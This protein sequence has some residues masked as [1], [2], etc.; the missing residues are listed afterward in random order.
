MTVTTDTKVVEDG[1]KQYLDSPYIDLFRVD[2]T[3]QGGP[4][5]YI[6]TGTIDTAPV[7]YNGQEY[8]PLPVMIEGLERTEEG[9]FPRPVFTVSNINLAFLSEGIAYDDFL[10]CDVTVVRMLKEYLDDQADP[11]K[12]AHWPQETFRVNR[13]LKQNKRYIS[14]E[15]VAPLDLEYLKIPSRQVLPVCQWY[16]RIYT[17]GD[18]NYENATCPY[19]GSGYFDEY[20]NACSAADDKCGKKLFD[21]RLRYT[22]I[23]EAIPYGG[24]PGVG[25]NLSKL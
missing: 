21:C 14:F 13:K 8:T 24:W 2:L 23:T 18:F 15:L 7:E 12:D 11:D 3:R 20:G 17:G 9:K 16:Y 4:I 10:N 1:F 25:I 22:D 6:T 19:T 5:H